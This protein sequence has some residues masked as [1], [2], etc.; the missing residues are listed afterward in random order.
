MSILRDVRSLG[1]RRYIWAR[2]FYRHVMKF[3]HRFDWHHA[4]RLGPFEDGSTQQWCQWC[5]LR[6]TTQKR[7]AP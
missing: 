6:M 4:P 2:F 7:S 3:A 1:L 5:G